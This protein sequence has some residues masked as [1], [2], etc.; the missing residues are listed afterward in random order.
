MSFDRAMMAATLVVP[1]ILVLAMR[2][3]WL[4]F[5]LGT[6]WFWGMMV[7]ACEYH[8]ATD[9][10]YDSIA[11]GISI[12]LGWCLGALYCAPWWV[13]RLLAR[14]ARRNRIEE[15]GIRPP[16]APGNQAAGQ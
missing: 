6:I 9:P 10:E 15:D 12:V 1:P 16:G 11:P 2:R 3:P 7:F 4:G 5:V 8:L 13:G 14:A